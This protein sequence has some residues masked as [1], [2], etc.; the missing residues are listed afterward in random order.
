MSYGI[1]ILRAVVGSTLA[2]HGAQKL[3]GW[4]DGPGLRGTAGF[5]GKLGLRPALPMAFAAGLSESAGV[6]F[7]IGLLTPLAAL[8]V[9]SVMVVAVATV[10]RP[11]GFWNTNG[12]FEYNL[13]LWTV[14][15]AVAAAGPGRFSVDRALGWDGA[16]SGLWWGAGVLGSSLLAGAC[17][18]A[19]RRPEPETEALDEP[20]QRERD[21]VFTSS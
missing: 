13:V 3:L 8:A 5:F 10:H 7:A 9:A 20:L 21:E 2:A 11:K 18:L 19:L 12:G 16:L 17:V 6:L 1:L 14:A 15:V 4:F